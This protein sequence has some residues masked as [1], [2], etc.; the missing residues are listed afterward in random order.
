MNPLDPTKRS[1]LIPKARK[2]PDTGKPLCRWCSSP[3]PKGRKSWC[4][5][6][7]VDDAL[8][9]TQPSY[10]RAAVKARDKG[11]CADCGRD[12]TKIKNQLRNIG[13]LA[14]NGLISYDRTTARAAARY[15]V[16]ARRL[17]EI[18][19]AGRT[20]IE[21]AADEERRLASPNADRIARYRET[22]LEV[23]SGEQKIRVI[24]KRLMRL[25]TAR[26]K[27]LVSELIA[28]GFD[29]I[30]ARTGHVNR[31][32]WD[33]DHIIPVVKGGGGCGLS[34]LRTLCQPCHKKASKILAGQLAAERK[35]LAALMKA[36]NEPELNL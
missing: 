9:R 23:R 32:L 14:R 34:N 25:A 35:A 16:P 30:C 18:C 24:H 15:D 6:A 36:S 22:P 1:N 33:A 8:I 26:L 12:T 29:G 17:Y 21:Y 31:S 2:C 13:T 4:S 10:A 5:Q 7:C 11:V 27:R 28:E 19:T 20:S 3:V